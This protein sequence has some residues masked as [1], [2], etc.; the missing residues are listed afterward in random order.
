[1]IKIISQNVRG[2]QNTQK[3][4]E[5]YLRW[6]DQA[7]ILCF[8]EAHCSI[9][10]EYIWS[11]EWG[12]KCIFSHGT[13]A[14]RGVMICFNRSLDYKIES[15]HRDNAGRYIVVQFKHNDSLYV[16]ANIYA[17]NQDSPSFFTEL[18]KKLDNLEGS[19]ILIGDFNLTLEEIDRKR[20]TNRINN[21]V[22]AAETCKN[23]MEE[24]ELIDIWR[25][26]NP[27][28]CKYSWSRKKP[29]SA[30]RLDFCL[31]DRAIESWV[32]NITYKDGYRSDHMAISLEIDQYTTCRGSGI[33]KIN[34][35]ILSDTEFVVR[36]N[37]KLIEILNN[38]PKLSK[39]DKWEMIKLESIG[40]AQKYSKERAS[41]FRNVISML[42]QKIEEYETSDNTNP[43]LDKTKQD[44]QELI[45]ERTNGAIFRS[46][47]TWYNEGEKT[48]KYFLN[49][50][51]SKSRAKNMSALLKDD[52]T[53]ITSPVEILNEQ[54]N[55]YQELYKKD[56][57][58]SFTYQNIENITISEQEKE[59]MEKLPSLDELS[60][61]LK[62]CKRNKTPGI[63]GLS[64]EFYVMFWKLLKIPLLE[65]LIEGLTEGE[66]H[67]SARKGVIT[68][69]PKKNKDARKIR[70]LRPITL[71]NTD[72]KLLEK[73]FANRLKPILSNLI[74][75][76]QKGFLPGRRISANIRCIIDI[77]HKVISEESD[78]IILSIDYEK[79]SK[80]WRSLCTGK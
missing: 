42:E 2:L 30:S 3:R 55:F 20:T 39:R 31:I 78:G 66:L 22:I 74:H 37:E 32:K 58:V 71:L 52:A 38:Y 13:P 26:R 65:A 50:E 5:L 14:A 27:N 41:N 69:I 80:S 56:E 29:I 64:A 19:K 61:A 67:H 79:S 25:A 33:W 28:I 73:V 17:P 12:G 59:T 10:S 9:N 75:T 57:S 40:L 62:T 44:L 48:S 63:D 35:Q 77:M 34:N 4:R 54:K 68:T 72:Y 21:N 60:M 6:R 43:L 24:V 8:Q 11:N 23:Y 51:K 47:A 7:D 36:M 16:L 76:D 45:A 46:K 1:M 70:N 18:F 49:L 15:I 53:V